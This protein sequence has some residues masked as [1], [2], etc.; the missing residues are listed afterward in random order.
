M[1]NF[2]AADKE[3]AAIDP[4]AGLTVLPVTSKLSS[5]SKAS[6]PAISTSTSSRKAKSSKD[7]QKKE[8]SKKSTP[9]EKPTSERVAC[10]LAA[11]YPQPGMEFSFEEIRAKRMVER[12][13]AMDTWHRW[14][15]TEKW[16]EETKRTGGECDAT[17]PEMRCPS[18]IFPISYDALL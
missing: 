11:I 10:D 5:D 7:E 18:D 13:N 15:W 12:N 2:S 4:L 3:L 6:V 9:A 1:K 16:E 17:V 14:E 8:R